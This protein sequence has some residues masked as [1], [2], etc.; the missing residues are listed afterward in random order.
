MSQPFSY[1]AQ[2]EREG[3]INADTPADA[4]LLIKRQTPDGLVFKGVALAPAS[5]DA[6]TIA[7]DDTGMRPLDLRNALVHPGK[8]DG[9][10]RITFYDRQ[11]VVCSITIEA[12]PMALTRLSPQLV[13][14]YQKGQINL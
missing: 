13:A 6:P 5:D 12:H 1:S 7:F 3:S 14:C 11:A 8:D 10:I 9:S 4:A 2:F